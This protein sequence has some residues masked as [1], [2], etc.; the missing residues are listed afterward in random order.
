VVEEK[1]VLAKEL[2]Q[3]YDASEFRVKDLR[4]EIYVDDEQY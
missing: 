1:D 4:L 2:N 3:H